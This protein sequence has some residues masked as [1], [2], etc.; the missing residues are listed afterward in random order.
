MS[1]ARTSDTMP[2]LEAVRIDTAAL[3]AFPRP[4]VNLLPPEIRSRRTLGRV[5]ARL[6]L[7]LL[8]VALVAGLGY[9]A[10]LWDES[11]AESDLASAQSEVLR[12]QNEQT[13]YAEVPLVKGQIADVEAARE[14]GM[15]TEVI[16][17][18]LLS[19]IQAVAPENVSIATLTISAP[20]PTQAAAPPVNPLVT[21]SIGS[22]TFT[23]T[24]TTLPDVAG[25]LEAL[26]SIPGFSD[27][28]FSSAEISDN[29]G[30]VGYDLTSTVQI[31]AT[32]FANR[33]VATEGN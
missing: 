14:Y 12:L 23:G 4:Q 27:A 1:A 33:F 30:V 9:V 17:V 32:V 7:S 28:D 25:W 20:S 15:S 21:S 26:N 6:G 31:D 19:A 22:I 11:A 24:S 13:K 10:A 8:I 2:P 3:G 5:K 18:E 16:W 29:E